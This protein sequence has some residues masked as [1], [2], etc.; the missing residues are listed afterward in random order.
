[1]GYKSHSAVSLQAT[2]PKCV[3]MSLMQSKWKRTRMAGRAVPKHA[4]REDRERENASERDRER[5]ENV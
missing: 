3:A 5:E 4:K 2:K 1:M